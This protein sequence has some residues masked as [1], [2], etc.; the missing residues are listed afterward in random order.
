MKEFLD[1]SL[2]FVWKVGQQENVWNLCI[3]VFYYF[4]FTYICSCFSVCFY[5]L[6]RESLSVLFP[7]A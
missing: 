1:V 6:L 4:F 5:L 7:P 2:K 3:A